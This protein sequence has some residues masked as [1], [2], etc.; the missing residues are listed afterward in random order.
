VTGVGPGRA[1]GDGSG[2][3]GAVAEPAVGAGGV[4]T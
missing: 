2:P 1:D 3:D 4:R